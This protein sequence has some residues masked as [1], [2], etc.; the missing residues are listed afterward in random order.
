MSDY[1]SL[2]SGVDNNGLSID[3]D[4]PGTPHKSLAACHSVNEE[5]ED[6]NRNLYGNQKLPERP[7]NVQNLSNH[8]QDMKSRPGAF[9][10]EFSVWIKLLRHS[11][12]CTIILTTDLAASRLVRYDIRAESRSASGEWESALLCNDVSHGLGAS[13]GSALDIDVLSGFSLRV[14]SLINKEPWVPSF[15]VCIGISMAVV[16]L[17]YG[18]SYTGKMA[19]LYW[20]GPRCSVHIPAEAYETARWC[21][22]NLFTNIASM[23]LRLGLVI[24]VLS[25][26]LN[27]IT[28]PCHD[29]TRLSQTTVAIRTWMIGCIPWFYV[30]VIIYACYIYVMLGNVWFRHTVKKIPWAKRNQINKLQISNIDMELHPHDQWDV[31]NHVHE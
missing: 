21:I 29:S 3:K 9:Q 8:I 17:S 30:D 13:L 4:R 5:E 2:I 31:I 25:F 20:D 12:T 28:H 10:S 6:E 24:A 26:L 27:V 23:I 1:I 14:S 11:C 15:Q 7:V 18:N 22:S 19:S 16:R